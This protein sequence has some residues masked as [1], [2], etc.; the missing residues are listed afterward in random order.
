MQ[1]LL[2]FGDTG[3]GD[4]LLAGFLI[5]LQLAV[6]TLPFGLLIG[7]GIALAGLSS[8]PVLRWSSKTYVTVMRGLP[9]I[10]TLFALYHGA[11][12]LLNGMV[13]WFIPD[14]GF[15]EFSP[16]VAGVLALALVFGAFSGEV[17]RGGFQS[18][19]KGQIEAASA[20]GMGSFLTFRRIKLPQVWR[21][22]LPGLSNLW[23]NLLK[24]TALVSV[25]GLSDLMRAANVA[26]GV[27]KKPFTFFLVACL[28]YWVACVISEI[29]AARLERDA[30]RGVRAA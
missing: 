24:D 17:L 19:P 2:A 1:A 13:K 7:L 29:V 20:S 5:T 22:A 28:L 30:N 8:S 23:V 6:I 21:F 18:I 9:E 12:L 27:T 15:V 14:A 26:V 10:L 16:F 25:I 11:G 4:E 3:W